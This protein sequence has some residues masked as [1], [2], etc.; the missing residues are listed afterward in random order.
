MSPRH[1]HVSPRHSR[2]SAL[3]DERRAQ[4]EFVTWRDITFEARASAAND[5]VRSKHLRG[6]GPHTPLA[7][8]K[9]VAPPARLNRHC[10]RANAA[11][12]DTPSAHLPPPPS[13]RL[14]G[15]FQKSHTMGQSAIGR[16]PYGQ[17]PDVRTRLTRL[18]RADGQR[19]AFHDEL[20]NDIGLSLRFVRALTQ[21]SRLVAVMAG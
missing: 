1:S 11:A 4:S 12:S 16:N 14:R 6:H 20:A 9:R 2:S 5:R 7:M 3:I 8:S 21:L 17:Q 18:L 10:H 15:T 13:R 19:I